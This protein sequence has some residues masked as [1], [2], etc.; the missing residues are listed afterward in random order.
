MTQNLSTKGAPMKLQSQCKNSSFY[1]LFA[2]VFTAAIAA[3]TFFF[4]PE[5]ALADQTGGVTP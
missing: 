5:A 4:T 2:A 1:L 3:T